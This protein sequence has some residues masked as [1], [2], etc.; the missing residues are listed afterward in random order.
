[1]CYFNETKINE[2]KKKRSEKNDKIGFHRKNKERIEHRKEK[3]K[4][5]NKQK[6]NSLEICNQLIFLILS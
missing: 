1:L 6:N 4:E 2:E 3:E 5:K